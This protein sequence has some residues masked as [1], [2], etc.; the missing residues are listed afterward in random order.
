M[1]KSAKGYPYE[2]YKNL[3]YF[4]SNIIEITRISLA[5]FD[6]EAVTILGS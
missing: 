4:F 5:D 6:I 1:K 3:P 2:E